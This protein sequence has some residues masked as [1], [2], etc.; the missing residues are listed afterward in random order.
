MNARRTLARLIAILTAVLVLTACGG[1]G[2]EPPA[3]NGEPTGGAT[4]PAAGG[5]ATLTISDF[6]F[7][8]TT[9]PAGGE[10]TVENSD[11]QTH[12]VTADDGDG[13]NARVGGGSSGSFSAPAEAGE[14]P[15]HCEI[16]ASMKGTLT[17]Q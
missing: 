6:T 11:Q 13:F 8:D 16:H 14:Y 7:S 1:G 4:Q 15:F 5:G 12:T 9:V 10:V 17:V 3:E 2:G